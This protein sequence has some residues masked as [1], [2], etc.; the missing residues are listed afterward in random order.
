MLQRL[1]RLW[2]HFYVQIPRRKYPKFRRYPNLLRT[3]HI[4]W[5]KPMYQK[6]IEL[7]QYNTV[8]W[9]INAQTDGHWAIADSTLTQQHV[10]KKCTNSLSGEDGR[11]PF[12]TF[13]GVLFSFFGASNLDKSMRSTDIQSSRRLLT[14]MHTL[15][16]PICMLRY[17]QWHV[18]VQ[19]SAT[20]T[21]P[22]STTRK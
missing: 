14:N 20:F 4:G 21:T 15:Q 10:H 1:D 22:L 8:M 19:Q 12:I 2:R 18:H 17:Q 7:L 9:Q 6:T 5:G 11:E 13:I 3:Q 16:Q